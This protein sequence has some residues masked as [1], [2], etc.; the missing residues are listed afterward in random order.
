MKDQHGEVVYVGKAQNLRARL[1]QYFAAVPGDTRFFV[2]LL[3]RVLGDIEVIRTHNAKEALILE[4]QLIK[5]HRPRY[6]VKLKDDKQFLTLRIGSEHRFP[7]LEVVRRRKQ[8]G[9]AYFGPYESA[10]AIRNALRVLNRHFQLRTCSDA[11]FRNR[12]RPCIEHQIGRCPAPCVFELAPGQYPQQVEEV[13]LFLSGR[14]RELVDR[15]TARMNAASER[16]DFELAARYRDQIRAIQRSLEPQYVRLSRVEDI[17]VLGLARGEDLA[18]VQVLQVRGGYLVGS[19]SFTLRDPAPDDPLVIDDFLRAH[20]DGTRPVPAWVLTP[21]PLDDAGAWEAWLGEAR[22]GAVRVRSPSRGDRA[23]LVGM[24]V[25]NA[26]H[27]LR[28]KSDQRAGALD[29]LGRL[30]ARLGLKSFPRRIECYDISNFQGKE[31]V[32]SMVVALDGE[33]AP[34]AYRHF[35]VHSGE[36]PDDFGMLREVLTRRLSSPPGGEEELPDLIVVDGGKG[37]LA[38]AMEV[39]AELGR[40][41]LELCG[42]AKS[43][44]LDA[45][46]RVARRAAVRP[47][48]NPPR[49]SG[50]RVFRPGIKDPVRLRPNDPALL[51]LMRIRDE[52]H[53]FAITHHGKRRAKRGLASALDQIPGIGAARR[54]AL[55]RHFG[56]LAGL[57]A[58]TQAQIAACPGV[59]P[60]TAAAVAQALIAPG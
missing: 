1:G 50:E 52:A 55:L 56:S 33:P 2:G 11:E 29:T 54:R 5:R 38:V 26:H 15:V 51:L 28:V 49:Q 9:G 17:D 42:L 18:V 37:Q 34:T 40:H 12:T 53:R 8:D 21:L 59:G 25:E 48:S 13:K 39:V 10:T 41:D 16:L 32:G 23:R 35:V 6:N 24:A 58:A 7:K 47:S 20:Y 36:E 19:R 45:L 44:A 46:G 3:D 4:D 14:P 31:P 30:Q 60:K 27:A 57:R 43:R 22:G